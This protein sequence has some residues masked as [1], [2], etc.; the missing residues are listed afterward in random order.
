VLEAAKL[1]G[2]DLASVCGGKGDCGKCRVIVERQGENVGALS[3]VEKSLLSEK[4][5]SEGYRLA[6]CTPVLSSIIVKIPENSR[7][8][9]QRLQ[10]EGIETPV[11]LEPFVEKYFLEL[12]RP[13]LQD[14]K[15]DVERLL[16]GLQSQKG[17][18]N[19]KI[20]FAVLQSLPSILRDSDWKVTVVL[21][22]KE[23]IIAVEPG[24][25]ANRI[26]GYALDI[27]TTKL[28]GYLLDLK[29]GKVVAVESSMNP[30]IPYGEDIITRIAYS[31]KGSKEQLE[32]QQSVVNSV[33]TI[34]RQLVE[35]AD[36]KNNEVYE[37]VAVGNTAMHHLFLNICPRFLA[38]SPYPPAIRRGIDVKPSSIG[39]SINPNG[40]IHVLPVIAGFV[41]ADTV[42]DILATET[43]K[44]SELCLAFDIGTNTEVFLGN[45]DEILACSCA[46]GP[47]LEGAHVKHG[48]RA[49]TGAIEKVTIDPN[50][51][52]VRYWTVDDAKPC[53]ICGSA[54]VDILAEMLK[55]GVIDVMGMMNR[56][57]A[58]ERLRAGPAGLEFVL[59]YKDETATAEDIVFTQ[60]DIMEIQLAKAAIHT[61]TVTLMRKKGVVEA[62]VDILFIAG[63]FGSY[64][65]PE[66]ARIIGMYPE[67][68]LEKVRVVG[69]AAGTGARM[70]LASKVSRAAAEE[71]SGKVK[72]VELAGEASF[73]AEYLNSYALPHADLSKYPQT[74]EILKTLGKYPEKSPFYFPT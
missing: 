23:T 42:A 26:F 7:T 20:D 14:P 10:I 45:K 12:S 69:N 46:S 67:I 9:R 44:R 53:G 63:A 27:G 43:Y 2:A 4:D 25:T 54:M 21:F 13:S 49:A 18:R 24:D 30:Q 65:D 37:A 74:S 58:S 41:G 38:L 55:A 39:V 59:A 11:V 6:C 33:N 57:L 22:Q 47:A 61:G 8:G 71:I 51:F 31:M 32:L 17:L 64:I 29:S 62:D 19:L 48:M 40:N 15:P 66:N 73:Q 56:N 70:A 50:T 52:A 3:S 28:A 16:D 34:L 72:Y 35:R 5:L 1:V 60:K 36:V 68:P